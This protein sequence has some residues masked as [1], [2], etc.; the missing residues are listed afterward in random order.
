MERSKLIQLRIPE[1]F[2]YKLNMYLIELRRT[3]VD[4]SKATLILE[5]AEQM[6]LKRTAKKEIK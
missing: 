6:L 3:G 2:D 4:K 1:Q 5:L